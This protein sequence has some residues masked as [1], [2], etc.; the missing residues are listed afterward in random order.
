MRRLE[1]V[2]SINHILSTI[3]IIW[4]YNYIKYVYKRCEQVLMLVFQMLTGL[5]KMFPFYQNLFHRPSKK[6]PINEGKE[7]FPSNIN[8]FP[9]FSETCHFKSNLM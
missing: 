4:Y 3:G 6:N 5:D 2:L 1:L 8:F 9:N 7:S